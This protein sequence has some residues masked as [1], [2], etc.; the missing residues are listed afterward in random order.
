VNKESNG[1][2]LINHTNFSLQAASIC[3][4]PEGFSKVGENHP[5]HL[6]TARV[7]QSRAD[8]RR[9]QSAPLFIEFDFLDTD[10]RCRDGLNGDLVLVIKI[11]VMKRLIWRVFKIGALEAGHPSLR[12]HA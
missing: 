2:D 1:K 5:F 10:L 11:V 6:G 4:N 7:S 12:P 8:T 3:R 9:D